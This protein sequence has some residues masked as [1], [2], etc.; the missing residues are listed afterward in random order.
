M[1][2]RL[3][4]QSFFLL[5][6]LLLNCSCTEEAPTSK[7]PVATPP[8]Q[9]QKANPVPPPANNKPIIQGPI[10]KQNGIIPKKNLDINF[11][12]C[13]TDNKV[14]PEN[15]VVL[16]LQNVT[17][18]ICANETTKDK[19]LGESHRLFEVKSS[20]NCEVLFSQKLP[21][22]VSADFPYYITEEACNE[23]SGWIGIR[24][25]QSVCAF[26]IQT[27]KLIPNLEPKFLRKQEAADA[28]S[29]MISHLFFDEN[30]MYGYAVDYGVF[31]FDMNKNGNQHLA[32]KEYKG[33][34]LFI[35]NRENKQ[36]DFIIPIVTFDENGTLDLKMKNVFDRSINV[37]PQTKFD[38]VKEK[39]IVLSEE[40]KPDQI[41]NL[42]ID[43][44]NKKRIDLPKNIAEGSAQDAIRFLK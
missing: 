20:P 32:I 7:T 43:M 44:V 16:P 34:Q 22:N 29:G 26:N 18:F 38:F 3:I 27:K 23:K 28:S 30:Y 14:L 17:A 39:Y 1:N 2:N 19:D 12:K 4:I 42:V 5:I 21:I 35:F 10:G 37:Y 33:T 41:S 9:N 6:L 40:I 8:P 13:E 15:T 11:K 36:K 25:F 24:G 31:V